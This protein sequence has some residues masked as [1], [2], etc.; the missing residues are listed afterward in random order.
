MPSSA[1]ST[2]RS[3]ATTKPLP[4]LLPLRLQ[5]LGTSAA[6]PFPGHHTSAVYLSRGGTS[7]LIDCGEGILTQV[8]PRALGQRGLDAVCISHLHGDHVYGLPGL[9]AS[10]S[11]AGR[12]RSLHLLGPPQLAAYVEAV[13]SF[14]SASSPFELLYSALPKGASQTPVL[15]LRDL[16]IDTLPLRH[17]VEAYG[18]CVSSLPPLRRLK[19]GVVARYAIPYERIDEIKRGV[20]L[21]MDESTIP[22]EA[23]TLDPHPRQAV[24]YLT[25]TAPLDA[26]PEHWPKAD[27]LLHDATF[28]P[29]DAQLALQTGHST[30]AQAAAFAKTSDA[31]TLL[32]THGS[33]RYSPEEREAMAR[34]ANILLRGH[35][36]VRWAVEGEVV[37][38]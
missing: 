15:T 21:A 27:I 29:A 1:S 12:T 30:T 25:D 36:K 22:N 14:T 10:M 17:R 33:V 8:P 32:L 6:R 24:A 19:P 16:V 37:D 28:A 18:F 34:D 20:A 35:S 9:L 4:V 2:T 31:A 23:L 5:V 38:I 13:F 26:W 7:V 3:R 11:L